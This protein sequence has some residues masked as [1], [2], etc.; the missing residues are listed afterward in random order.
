MGVEVAIGLA[1][2]GAATSA[3][4]Q[5]RQGKDAAAAAERNA[6]YARV[7]ARD[8]LERGQAAAGAYQR[9]GSRIASQQQAVAASS[10]QD[11]STGSAAAL[12]QTTR[13]L[14][15]MDALEALNNAAREAR[16]YRIQA[17]ESLRQGAQAERAGKLGAAGTLLGGI[18][19]AGASYYGSRANDPGAPPPLT[20]G[21]R[22]LEGAWGPY[23]WHLP[24]G[25]TR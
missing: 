4:G 6:A 22:A 23:I 12:Q 14:S 16:G 2:A 25:R 10:G 18:G 9:E 11:V 5:I 21:Q 13:V 8:A 1:L 3:Y 15:E 7:A 19:Q 17:S 24:T 20:P